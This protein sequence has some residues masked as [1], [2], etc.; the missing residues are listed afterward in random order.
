MVGGN[1]VK[2]RC[3]WSV[4]RCSCCE[5]GTVHFRDEKLQRLKSDDQHLTTSPTRTTDNGQRTTDN[6]QNKDNGQN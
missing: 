4:V 2:V 6:G 5:G 1:L 3:Q